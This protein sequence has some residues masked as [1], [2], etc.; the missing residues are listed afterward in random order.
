MPSRATCSSARNARAAPDRD[1]AVLRRSLEFAIRRHAR[2]GRLVR[3]IGGVRTLRDFPGSGPRPA[4]TGGRADQRAALDLISGSVLSPMRLAVSPA[5]S[6]AGA[7]LPGP[8][9][10]AGRAGGLPGA[11]APARAA[12]RAC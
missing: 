6:G 7:R 11:A 3:Q 8:R 5:C 10:P 4:G 12:A 9:G 1:Y 2:D